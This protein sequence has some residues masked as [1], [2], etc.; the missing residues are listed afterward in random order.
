MNKDYWTNLLL[1]N[2]KMTFEHLVSKKGKSRYLINSSVVTK[3]EY[4]CVT[5]DVYSDCKLEPNPKKRTKWK[6][7][8]AQDWSGI[9][10]SGH[11]ETWVKVI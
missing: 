7:E 9:K 3:N 1:S 6:R 5:C 4:E 10:W 8:S 11:R 2:D